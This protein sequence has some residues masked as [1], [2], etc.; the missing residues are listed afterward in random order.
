MVKWKKTNL[1]K[2]QLEKET[3]LKKTDGE[4]KEYENPKA[5]S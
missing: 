2:P 3:G 1:N 5:S 4:S